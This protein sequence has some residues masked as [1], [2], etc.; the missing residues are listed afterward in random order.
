MA[1]VRSHH[2]QVGAL[3]RRYPKDLSVRLSG[4]DHFGKGNKFI[5]PMIARGKV[6]VGTPDGVAEFGLLR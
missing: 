2:N 6:F 3:F 4:R 1:P 5:T